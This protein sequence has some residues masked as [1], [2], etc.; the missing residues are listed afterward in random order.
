MHVDP[1]PELPPFRHRQN[2]FDYSMRRHSIDPLSHP[3]SP[4]RKRKMSCDRGSGFDTVGEEAHPLAGPGVPSLMEVD[5]EAPARKRRGSAF[6]TQRIAQLSLNERRN[7]VD[8]R[9][10]G[11]WNERRDSTSSSIISGTS[12]TYSSTL[13]GTDS[14]H[15]RVPPSM[16][17]FSWP[18]SSST[19]LHSINMQHEI[20][21][22]A[23]NSKTET[24]NTL[25]PM[26]L[27]S[28]RRMSVPDIPSS[29]GSRA[30]RSRS[31]PPSRQ[32]REQGS[33]HSAHSS[34]QEDQASPPL[35][36]KMKEGGSA[37]Y[38]RSPELRV[39]HKLAERKRRKEMKDLFD[40]LRDH[41][42]ADR[43]MKASKW[44]ILSKGVCMPN[45]DG[46]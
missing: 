42:P 12:T 8:S 34:G 38:S 20:D 29:G 28:E 35:Y 31:R 9:G 23:S 36:S 15:G 32:R 33:S 40:E 14:S 18:S 41:L 25:P 16:A 24:R 22:L 10:T 7:S 44:E 27:F 6:D 43:G 2:S 3:F 39:S 37:P 46:P 30:L 45:S 17:S 11:W 5:A 26:T 19:S 21:P 1:D 13:S 4:G